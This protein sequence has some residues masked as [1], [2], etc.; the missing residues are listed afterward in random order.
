MRYPEGSAVGWFIGTA[1]DRIYGEVNLLKFM[2]EMAKEDTIHTFATSYEAIGV[3]SQYNQLD[4][5]LKEVGG[6]MSVA[7]RREVAGYIA[8]LREAQKAYAA[9]LKQRVRFEPAVSGKFDAMSV[10]NLEGQVIA[11]YAVDRAGGRLLRNEQELARQ[12]FFDQFVEDVFAPV[13]AAD[14]LR[15]VDAT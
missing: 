14:P 7:D 12:E 15:L 13:R 11:R 2:S 9:A 3:I 5:R 1:T 10:I 6:K 4:M 8:S